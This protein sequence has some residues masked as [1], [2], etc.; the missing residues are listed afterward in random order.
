MPA[1]LLL[2][3]F[4]PWRTFV[5]L[6]VVPGSSNPVYQRRC[7]NY[8]LRGLGSVKAFL[9]ERNPLWIFAVSWQGMGKSLTQ[10]SMHGRSF[11]ESAT[12]DLLVFV[13][14]ALPGEAEG[15]LHYLHSS[16]GTQTHLHTYLGGLSTK[17]P[18]SVIVSWQ[19]RWGNFSEWQK[20]RS[21]MQLRDVSVQVPP[22]SEGCACAIFFVLLAFFWVITVERHPLSEEPLQPENHSY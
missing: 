17:Q 9:L 5:W 14:K 1:F 13:T 16:T 3:A 11:S 21:R 20:P 6:P 2:G 22:N 4:R 15:M 12:S 7:E 18:S 10:E 19:S 8:Y